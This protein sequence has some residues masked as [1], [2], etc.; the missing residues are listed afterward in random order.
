MLKTVIP[1]PPGVYESWKELTAPHDVRVV[2]TANRAEA[3]IPN[4]VSLPSIIPPA[5]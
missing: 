4:R 3:Q 1:P 2:D 5:A